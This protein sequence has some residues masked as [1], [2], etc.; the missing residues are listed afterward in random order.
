MHSGA[1][2]FVDE[3]FYK[4]FV[5]GRLKVDQCSKE[6]GFLDGPFAFAGVDDKSFFSKLG[7]NFVNKFH[8]WIKALTETG[9]VVDVDFDIDDVMEH[10]FHDFLSN[11]GW[12]AYSHG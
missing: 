11:V 5:F 7:Q 9:N 12:L 2:G 10:E 1:N 8:V 6:I 3:M 4:G